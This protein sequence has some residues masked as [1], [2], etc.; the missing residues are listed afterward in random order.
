[1]WLE[2]LVS[3]THVSTL[4]FYYHYICNRILKCF[5]CIQCSTENCKFWQLNVFLIDKICMKNLRPI[6]N[7]TEST[8]IMYRLYNVIYIFRIYFWF[9][10]WLSLIEDATHLSNFYLICLMMFSKNVYEENVSILTSKLLWIIKI[11]YPT[12]V[13]A[14]YLISL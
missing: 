8:G 14:D 7:F 12:Q 9:T 5:C 6:E 3:Q 2:M 1:M 4:R 10:C 13:D 11:R